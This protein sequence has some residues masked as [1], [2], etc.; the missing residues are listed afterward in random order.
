M[1]SLTEAEQSDIAAAKEAEIWKGNSSN[2]HNGGEYYGGRRESDDDIMGAAI[3]GVKG[4]HGSGLKRSNTKEEMVA[5]AATATMEK[6]K[7]VQEENERLRHKMNE[8]EQQAKCREEEMEERQKAWAKEKEE[9]LRALEAFTQQKH[10]SEALIGTVEKEER[11]EKEKSEKRKSDKRKVSS[12]GNSHDGEELLLSTEEGGTPSKKKSKHK[13][14]KASRSLKISEVKGLL[15]PTKHRK[16]SKTWDDRGDKQIGGVLHDNNLDS[17]YAEAGTNE[18]A[19]DSRCACKFYI[20]PSLAAG[21]CLA[22]YETHHIVHYPG[23]A[24]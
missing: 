20:P 21:R 18:A 19:S 16:G 9:L 2:H 8:L 6:A 11:K 5:A 22:L 24:Q 3:V 12:K 10:N 14:K 4:R 23:E 15:S 7:Q 17:S 13:V 1:F